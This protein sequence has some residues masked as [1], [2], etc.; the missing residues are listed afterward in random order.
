MELNR[1]QFIEV[2][3]GA[4][5]LPPLEAQGPKTDRGDPDNPLGVRRDFPVVRDGTYLN[6]AYATLPFAEVYQLGAALTYLER[7]AVDRIDRHTVALAREL[8]EGL[9]AL[10]FSPVH[11]ARQRHVDRQ[12]TPGQ[13]SD[14][15]A[16]CSMPAT[17]RSASGRRER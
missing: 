17:C 5:A 11:A 3:A 1:R 7:I 12:R 10:G 8:R 15:R 4:A 2:A 6:S 9:A 13:K 16:R 14:P